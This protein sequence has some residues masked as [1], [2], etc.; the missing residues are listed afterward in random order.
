MTP[1]RVYICG[2]PLDHVDKASALEYA[3]RI[4]QNNEKCSI[5]AI[6]PEKVIAAH[7]DE[8]FKELLKSSELLIPD[9][10]GM[11]VAARLQGIK[12]NGRVPGVE[13]AIELC[14]L[15]A[16]RGY[17]VY[18]FG[19]TEETSSAA[20]EMLVNKYPTLR[21]AGRRNGYFSQ[22]DEE[23]IMRDINNSNAQI[24]LVAL[25]SP[26]QEL[27]IKTNQRKLNVN[28]LQGVGGTLD[29][30]AGN[31]KR[32]P[33]FWRKTNLEWLYRLLTQPRR[34]FRQTA[35]PAFV[36]RVIIDRVKN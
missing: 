32:A 31:V 9:G 4:I 12:L 16:D 30:I 8:R 22:E 14:K 25:G 20:A 17:G 11:I 26:K 15:A 29:V 24:A 27:W 34:I 28:V 7:R 10:I 36:W 18:L 19:A 6:N 23:E 33:A 21:I 1:N 35:L 5:I 3:N 2:V 13:L